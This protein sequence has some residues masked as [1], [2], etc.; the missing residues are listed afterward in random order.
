MARP[1]PPWPALLAALAL[2]ATA[3]A[4][5]D[6]FDAG[7]AALDA[8]RF[9]Q[10]AA[11]FEAATRRPACAADAVD[12]KFNMGFALQQ[13][14]GEGDDQA[15]CG[16]I[17]AYREVLAAT[18][19]PDLARTARGRIAALSPRCAPPDEGPGWPLRAA[20]AAGAIAV[21][22]GVAY[23]LALQADGE[24]E[25]AKADYVALRRAGDDAGSRAAKARFEDARDRTDAMGYTAYVGLG[26]TVALTGLAI[27]GYLVTSDGPSVAVGPGGFVL[28]G[29]F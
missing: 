26:L 10:A 8:R 27:G 20:I 18:P 12:L 13:L 19:D 23:G 6:C 22:T 21:A 16:A 5:P 15:A 1:L 28:R 24:R 14:A 17:D 25:D 3:T 4:A 2:P 29:R 11:A 7:L 9:A